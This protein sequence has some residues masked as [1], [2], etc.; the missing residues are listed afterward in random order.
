[1]YNKQYPGY[2][3][4][5]IVT[6]NETF[7]ELNITKEN[8]VEDQLPVLVN[9]WLKYTKYTNSYQVCNYNHRKLLRFMKVKSK[10]VPEEFLIKISTLPKI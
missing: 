8:L 2:I 3:T 6:G 5:T 9:F 1:M 7:P 10:F 4:M